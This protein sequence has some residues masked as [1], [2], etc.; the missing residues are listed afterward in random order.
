MT[1]ED[2]DSSE[3]DLPKL[4]CTR[5]LRSRG[6]TGVSRVE[7][8]GGESPPTVCTLGRVVPDGQQTKAEETGEGRDLGRRTSLSVYLP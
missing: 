3:D 2:P 7:S 4:D 5:N 6:S 1:T 8:T